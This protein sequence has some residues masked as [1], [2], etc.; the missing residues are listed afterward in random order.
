ML[1]EFHSEGFVIQYIIDT[2][3][4]NSERLVFISESAENAPPGLKARMTF[5]LKD[6]NAFTEIFELAFAGKEF[7]E[8]L[9]NYWQLK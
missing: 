9:K 5:E 2:V 4:S 3:S 8:W 7:S 1:R 6:E